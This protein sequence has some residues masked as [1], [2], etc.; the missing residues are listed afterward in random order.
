M[1][2]F[3]AD[4]VVQMMVGKDFSLLEASDG[5]IEIDF[6][7]FNDP[8]FEFDLNALPT[9]ILE[10]V[11]KLSFNESSLKLIKGIFNSHLQSLALY[12]TSTEDDLDWDEADASWGQ[13]LEELI[14]FRFNQK[15]PIGNF[16]PSE[17]FKRLQ[18]EECEIT[19]YFPIAGMKIE[20]LQISTDELS[21]LYSDFIDDGARF[22]SLRTLSLMGTYAD[23]KKAI[24]KIKPEHL[25]LWDDD[26]ETMKAASINSLLKSLPI[27]CLF[28]YFPNS[29]AVHFDKL[30]P[31][32]QIVYGKDGPS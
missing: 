29:E 8:N 4:A 12:E 32:P 14:L 27:E 24:K 2:I 26:P 22:P 23:N 10:R 6:S 17:S 21:L 18:V 25:V 15:F 19:S 16:S 20:H 9:T 1:A 30:L 3:N 5:K 28:V 31:K 7:G 11:Y 13:S